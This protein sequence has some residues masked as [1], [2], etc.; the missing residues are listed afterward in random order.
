MN[1][2]VVVSLTVVTA[3]HEHIARATEVMAR[4][5]TGLVLDGIDANLSLGIPSEDDDE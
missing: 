1:P 3:D 2:V 5:A 4:A